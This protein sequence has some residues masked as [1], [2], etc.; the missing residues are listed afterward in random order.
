[1]TQSWQS[2]ERSTGT[3]LIG[4]A[5]IKT[6]YIKDNAF[7]SISTEQQFTQCNYNNEIFSN[8]MLILHPRVLQLSAIVLF[9]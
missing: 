6:P 1:M 7:V 3:A 2:V 9:Y 8:S 5:E 4:Q